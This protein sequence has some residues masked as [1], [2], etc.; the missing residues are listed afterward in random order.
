MLRRT[1]ISTFSAAPLLVVALFAFDCGG[2]GTADTG[3]SGAPATGGSSSASG[4]SVANNGG[5]SS[6]T[7][8]S[9]SG[10]NPATGGVSPSTGGSAA[11]GGATSST[12][13]AD[14]TTG[15][16]VSTSGGKSSTGGSSSGGAGASTGGSGGA[17][18]AG[19]YYI[20][21]T[22]ADTNPG[23]EAAPFLTLGKA[24]QL[25]KAGT[26]IWVMSGTFK[27]S[28]TMTLD[29]KGSMMAPIKVWAV[30]GARPVFDFSGQARGSSTARGIE[31]KGDYVHIRGIE[32]MKAGDNGIAISGSYNTVEDVILHGNE[33]TGLQ[34][35]VPSATVVDNSRGANNLILNCDSHDN[36]DTKASGGNADG[37]AAKINIGPG[38]KFF[39]CVAHDNSD[40]GWDTFPK[41]T[42]GTNPVTIENCIAYHNGYHNGAAAGNGNGFKVGSDVTGGAA[43][44]V[45]NSVAFNNPSKGFDQNHNLGVASIQNCT[46]LNNARNVAFQENGGANITNTVANGLWEQAGGTDSGNVKT[47]ATSAFTNLTPSSISRDADGTLHLNGFCAYTPSTAGAHF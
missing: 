2:N 42:S 18:A 29:R 40:D 43:H 37:F 5:I 14:G 38:N 22:G 44:V 8:G 9:G 32:V 16:A 28:T 23:T 7:G 45:K 15:G 25:A 31:L 30:S 26:T 6:T 17:T 13:G 35:T 12:G 21:P 10:G 20:S 27:Y 36:Y 3:G 24:N 11:S 34:I 1:S 39:G 19:D 41:T 46:A 33:D 47:A 4:G